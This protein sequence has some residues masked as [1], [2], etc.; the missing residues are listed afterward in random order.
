[1]ENGC[2]VGIG[3]VSLGDEGVRRFSQRLALDSFLTR[4]RWSRNPPPDN[5][6]VSQ[7]RQTREREREEREMDNVPSLIKPHTST[8]TWA[9][10]L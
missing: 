9:V 10:G 8:S 3:G 4:A 2:C 7:Q 5:S 1:M 6:N